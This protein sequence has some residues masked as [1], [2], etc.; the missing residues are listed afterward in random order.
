MGDPPAK[1][2]PPPTI[3]LRSIEVRSELH[4]AG[5]P[6]HV[7]LPTLDAPA[8]GERY[9]P[10]RYEPTR[11]EPTALSGVTRSSAGMTL[12]LVTIAMC[13]N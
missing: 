9:K 10:A 3:S 1:P 12:P 6:P 4:G 5:A 13:S 11:Y 2:S 7:G 8:A